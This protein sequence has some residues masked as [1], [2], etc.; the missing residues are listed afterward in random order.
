MKW[1]DWRLII[2]GVLLAGGARAAEPSVDADDVMRELADLNQTLSVE[3]LDRA[4][5]VQ[6]RLELLD[7]LESK[8]LEIA[9][10]RVDRKAI[11]SGANAVGNHE[12]SDKPL[13][14]LEADP[15]VVD[16]I[17]HGHDLT[18]RLIAADRS[19]FAVKVGSRLGTYRVEA[20]SAASG[21]EVV[22]GKGRRHNL[23]EVEETEITAGQTIIGP[24]PPAGVIPPMSKR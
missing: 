14:E 9:K 23:P 15:R 22:D 11:E 18:A 13:L 19:S 5:E 16:I 6:A 10:K 12:A 24:P 20:I 2:C 3:N 4:H 8:L 21:V 17:G 7:Q 1:A